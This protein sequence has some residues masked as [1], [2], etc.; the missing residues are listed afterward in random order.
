MIENVL[1]VDPKY[2]EV[3]RSTRRMSSLLV[4]PRILFGFYLRH[5]PVDNLYF[6]HLLWRLI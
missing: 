4:F 2:V 5:A 3:A 6:Q 1:E